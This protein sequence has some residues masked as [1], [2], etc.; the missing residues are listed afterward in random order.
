MLTKLLFRRYAGELHRDLGALGR[1]G[2]PDRDPEGLVVDEEAT[3]RLR[4][5]E[6]E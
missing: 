6:R 1:V 5:G 4:A 2:D 3:A